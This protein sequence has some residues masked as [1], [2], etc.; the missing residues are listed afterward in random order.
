MIEVLKTMDD[1]NLSVFIRARVR[2]R[3]QKF[4]KK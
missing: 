2:E 1:L 4:A 3:Y